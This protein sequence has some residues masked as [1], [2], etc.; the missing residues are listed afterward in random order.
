MTIRAQTAVHQ[1]VL[2]GAR[3]RAFRGLIPFIEDEARVGACFT[4]EAVASPTLTSVV[5]G[6]PEL[7]GNIT[8]DPKLGG[9]C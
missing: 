6:G 9:D 7:A 5:A 3:M 1:G 2:F 8:P 4:G